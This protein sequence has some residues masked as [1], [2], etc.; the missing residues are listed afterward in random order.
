MIYEKVPFAGEIGVP[1]NVSRYILL[2]SILWNAF[3]KQLKLNST[4]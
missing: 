1:E 2:V 4:E 3:S